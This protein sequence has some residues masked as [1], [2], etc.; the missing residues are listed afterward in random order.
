[1]FIRF[2]AMTMDIGIVHA[3]QSRILLLNTWEAICN[4]QDLQSRMECGAKLLCRR[5]RIYQ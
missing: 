5:L 1:M 2:Y 4:E 3:W